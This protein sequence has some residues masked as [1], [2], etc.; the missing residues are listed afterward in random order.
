MNSTGLLHR[1]TLRSSTCPGR[2]ARLRQ[3]EYPPPA[4]NLYDAFRVETR[5][6]TDYRQLRQ[7]LDRRKEESLRAR[8]HE[9]ECCN[10]A[11]PNQTWQC[12]EDRWSTALCKAARP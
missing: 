3:N 2:V 11:G 4:P 6:P 9:T 5:P 7:P 1:S 8:S 12:R 10:E